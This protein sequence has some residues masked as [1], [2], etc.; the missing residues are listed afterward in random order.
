MINIKKCIVEG[1]PQFSM[2]PR[3]ANEMVVIEGGD[4]AM[5][6]SSLPCLRNVGTVGK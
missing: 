5:A 3:L 6:M 2:Q 1:A 4:A